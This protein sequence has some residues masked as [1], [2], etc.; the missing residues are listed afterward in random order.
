MAKGSNSTTYNNTWRNWAMC[1]SAFQNKKEIPK[2]KIYIG[3]GQTFYTSP[4]PNLPFLGS[5]LIHLY[6]NTQPSDITITLL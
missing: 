5:I 1:A 2:I 3:R 4:L 6:N